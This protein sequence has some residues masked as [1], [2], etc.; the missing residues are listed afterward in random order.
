VLARVPVGDRGGCQPS[1]HVVDEHLAGLGLRLHPRGC[2]HAVAHDQTLIGLHGGHLSRHDARPGPQPW[3]A[4][5][6]AEHADGV[7]ELERGAHRALGILLPCHRHAPHGHYRIPDELLDRA[8]VSAH[9]RARGLEVTAQQLPHVLRFARLRQ[10]RETDE[11]DEQHRHNPQ[12]GRHM[13]V[14]HLRDG[15]CFGDRPVHE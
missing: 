8:A 7:H 1:C 13:A 9:D 2:V 12:L 15:R 10:R 3:D 11:V 4:Y 14:D 5:L 6:R